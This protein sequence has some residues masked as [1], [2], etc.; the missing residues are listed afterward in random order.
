MYS[1][2][3]RRKNQKAIAWASLWALV[4]VMLFYALSGVIEQGAPQAQQPSTSWLG[5]FNVI[6]LAA[7]FFGVFAPLYNELRDT[8]PTKS[9]PIVPRE[10]FGWSA[11]KMVILG[12]V[13]FI[14]LRISGTVMGTMLGIVSLV[15]LPIN[16]FF[17]SIYCSLL[18]SIFG[19]FFVGRWIGHRCTNRGISVVL[20]VV[21]VSQIFIWGMDIVYLGAPE[22]I[23]ILSGIGISP[24]YMFLP[25]L[26]LS[27]IG[28]I[29]YWRGRRHRPSR[30]LDYLIGMLPSDTQNTLVDLAYS[31]T[32]RLKSA[33]GEALETP[34]A[35]DIHPIPRTDS[36]N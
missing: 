31:E 34:A 8:F 12:S 11:K 18:F 35:A 25:P 32:K 36:G 24:W 23:A 2:S 21:F 17:L 19:I 26:T 15:L 7:L 6:G 29:G 9:D 14:V 27:G 10:G 16:L 33:N 4:V 30:Y 3:F 22:Y 28:L 1:F 5:Q 20:L 13:M